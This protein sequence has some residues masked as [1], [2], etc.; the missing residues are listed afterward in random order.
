[1][2]SATTAAAKHHDRCYDERNNSSNADPISILSFVGIALA[3]C[4]NS[5]LL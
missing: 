1:M 4:S 3:S 2:A 5:L